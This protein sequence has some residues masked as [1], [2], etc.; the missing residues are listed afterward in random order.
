M[1]GSQMN[2]LFE[3]T[4]ITGHTGLFALFASPASHS[5]SPAMFNASFRATGLDYVYLAFDVGEEEIGDAVRAAR[6]LGIKMFNLSMPNKTAVIPHLDRISAEAELAGAVNT[7]IN[8]NGVLTGY[9][10]DGYGALAAF[11]EAGGETEGKT[12]TVLGAGGA[13][14]AVIAQLALDGAKKISVMLR[15]G[16]FV[17][18]RTFMERVHE[19]TGCPVEIRDIEDEKEVV[20]AITESDA[21]INT[22]NVGMNPDSGRTPVPFTDAFHRG[23]SVFDVIYYPEETRLMKDARISGCPVVAGGRGMLLHQGARGFKLATGK[24]MPLDIVK[25]EWGK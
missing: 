7:V 3:T 10:T 19:R 8:E 13:G 6:L 1:K 16:S 2:D 17:K 12:A 18:H 24:D 20:A 9:N 5:G 15:R 21:L 22:T 14:R 4:R 23:L 11:A 25:R